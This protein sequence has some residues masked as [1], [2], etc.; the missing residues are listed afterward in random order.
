MNVITRGIRNAFRNGVRTLSIVVILGLSIGLSLTMLIAHQAVEDK[1][2]SVKSSIGNTISVSP[3]GVQGFQGGGDPLA[4]STVDALKKLTHVTS[5]SESISDQMRS[6]NT[7]LTSAIDAGSL[8]KRFN[9]SSSSGSSSNGPT[10]MIGGSNADGSTFT[11]PVSATGTSDTTKLDGTTIK[12]T[13]G[14]QISGTTD[15]DVALVGKTLATKNSLKVG[16]TFTAYGETITVAGIY[17]T[18]T[19][20]SNNGVIFSLPTLQRLSDQTSDI[21]S[22]TV[23]VDSISNM[24][25]VTSA[26]KSKLGSKAD[27]TN[28]KSSAESAIKPLESIG[29]VSL[30]SLLG[31]TIAGAVIILLVMIMVVR[32]RKREIGVVKAIGG[33][34]LRIM[35]EFMIESLTLTVLGAII[36]LIIGITAGQPVTKLLVNN[37]TSSTSTTQSTSPGQGGPRVIS[38]LG[39]SSTVRGIKNIKAEIGWGILLDGFGAAVFI[40]AIGS[41]LAA[42]MI[43]KVRPSQVMRAD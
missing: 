42:G 39:D 18:G 28:S 17:D 15:K 38:R 3:A 5:V 34:N 36:G 43:A 31:A 14:S 25:S 35:S 21:T 27:V 41:A 40:A 13:S 1:I 22:A 2:K 30:F 33:S 19:E 10:M 24:D 23:Y 20:F 8:G 37:S 29:T 7:S 16:S 12:L 11:P 26:V 9:S 6:S 4:Q 32:E